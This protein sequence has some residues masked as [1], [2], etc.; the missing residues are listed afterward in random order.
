MPH[1]A[2]SP[3]LPGPERARDY[4]AHYC[5]DQS[6]KTGAWFT[7]GVPVLIVFAVLSIL[8]VLNRAQ[9]APP[10]PSG[11]TDFLNLFSPIVTFGLL[12]AGLWQWRTARREMSMDQ[13]YERLNIANQ[14]WKSSPSA[15]KL[16]GGFAT[17]SEDPDMT[18]YVC[19]EIDNLEYVIEKY[20]IGYVDDEQACRGLKA[21]EIRCL[22]SAEFRQ[23]ARRRVHLGDYTPRTAK[24]VCRVCD[25]VTNLIEHHRASQFASG[26]PPENQ[27]HFHIAAAA[28]INVTPGPPPPPF[29]AAK[30]GGMDNSVLPFGGRRR[31]DRVS[32]SVSPEGE[33]ASTT[34]SGTAQ[35]GSASGEGT[36]KDGSPSSADT[37]GQYESGSLTRREG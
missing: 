33:V 27:T 35:A 21:F 9:S 17:D 7:Y 5:F 36:G 26:I 22:A 10:S 15:R 32:G 11:P 20:R 24:V 1:H 37:D 29:T 12:L 6:K 25:E 14:W 16:M 4:L 23:I 28:A 19:L 13:Y 30:D 8:I 34:N 2:C 31:S 3:P 18:M